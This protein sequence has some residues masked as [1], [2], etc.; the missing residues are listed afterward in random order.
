MINSTVRQFLHRFIQTQQWD[1][2]THENLLSKLN[3]LDDSTFKQLEFVL[4]AQGYA[5]ETTE[6]LEQLLTAQLFD[7]YSYS[8]ANLLKLSHYL[9]QHRENIPLS[10]PY[11]YIFTLDKLFVEESEELKAGNLLSQSMPVKIITYDIVASVIHN[12]TNKTPN[13]LR[14]QFSA[15]PQQIFITTSHNLNCLNLEFISA[16][17]Y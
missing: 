14:K 5:L 8:F 12:L 9:I 7:L 4:L 2:R 17:Y 11:R 1:S 13:P 6:K 10:T 15:S 3:G 16:N